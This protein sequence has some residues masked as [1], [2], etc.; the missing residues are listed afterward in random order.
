MAW[1]ARRQF[2]PQGWRARRRRAAGRRRFPFWAGWVALIAVS[3][4]FYWVVNS[5]LLPATGQ[6]ATY[7]CRRNAYNCSDFRTRMEA[8]AAY[9]ACG[10]PRN[11]VH[12]LDEDRDG[13][14]CERLPI[15]PWIRGY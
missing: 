6:G 10:G 14:A 15:I 12:G 5:T 13:L 8:Q 9:L 3:A 7:Q 2:P 1:R 11:D 4:I